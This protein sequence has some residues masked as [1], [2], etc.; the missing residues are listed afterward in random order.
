MSFISLKRK[1]SAD[2]ERMTSGN[3]ENKNMAYPKSATI[4]RKLGST[5]HN[6]TKPARRIKSSQINPE[7]GDVP[8]TPPPSRREHVQ[9]FLN[10]RKLGDFTNEDGQISRCSMTRCSNYYPAIYRTF[11]P[12]SSNIPIESSL[13]QT[14]IELLN[15]KGRSSPRENVAERT[16]SST[17]DQNFAGVNVFDTR[18]KVVF[19]SK[20]NL[21]GLSYPRNPALPYNSS[22]ENLSTSNCFWRRLGARYDKADRR[23]EPTITLVV[24]LPKIEMAEPVVTL[25]YKHGKL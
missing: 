12:D 16:L 3:Y 10:D 23:K 19:P 6:A 2:L 14:M 13:R 7:Q 20:K 18:Y 8:V 5:S 22:L 4:F 24:S 21:P 25:A 1:L 11:L 17:K 9:P 15:S